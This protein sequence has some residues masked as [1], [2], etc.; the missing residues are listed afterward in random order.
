M[1][2]PWLYGIGAGIVG[3][4]VWAFARPSTASAATPAKPGAK[5]PVNTGIGFKQVSTLTS[6]PF[7]N[8]VPVVCDGVIWLV[9]PNYLGP[10]GIGEAADL[11]KSAGGELPSPALV[12]A[13]WRQADLKILPPTR[14]Q[15][16]VSAA[17]FADQQAR[18]ERL[19][20]DKPY[21]LV[22]GTFKDV[23]MFQGHPQLYGWHVEDGRSV[24]INLLK[25]FT[26]GPG[27]IIQPLSGGAHALSYID[28]SQGVRIVRRA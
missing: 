24:G 16:V 4:A 10:V 2:T 21:T 6:D 27:K 15:N 22:G 20:G 8:A 5:P 26:P 17:V 28:Y 12:D 1:S 19:V 3:A 7:A 25:P 13:I 23:V 11:A 9:A 14:A 18:I